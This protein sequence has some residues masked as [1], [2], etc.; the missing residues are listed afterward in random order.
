VQVEVSR[1][2]FHS[3]QIGHHSLANPSEQLSLHIESCPTCKKKVLELSSELNQ[4]ELH[5]ERYQIPNDIKRELKQELAEVI[6][7][8]TPKLKDKVIENSK[9]INKE[10]KLNLYHFAMHMIQPKNL[11]VIMITGLCAFL[12]HQLSKL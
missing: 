11:K 9:H 3:K 6:D 1:P 2:C 7:S 4:V 10:M 8:F 12:A 5:F